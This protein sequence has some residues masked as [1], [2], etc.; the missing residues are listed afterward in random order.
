[1]DLS[2]GEIMLYACLLYYEDRRTHTCYPSFR[3]IG[4]RIG[5]SKNTVIP[6][7]L[8]WVRHLMRFACF[9]TV[10]ALPEGRT[11]IQY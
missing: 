1:M 11:H 2:G 8:T 6:P 5:M 10:S 9:H 4:E 7:Q 3:E